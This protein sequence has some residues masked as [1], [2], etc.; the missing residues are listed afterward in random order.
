MKQNCVSKNSEKNAFRL[1]EK[2]YK[3]YRT[4]KKLKESDLSNVIDFDNLELNTSYNKK[5]INKTS[6]NFREKSIYSLEGYDGF[7]FIPN[8][9]SND[10]QIHWYLKAGKEYLLEN[11]S[12][13]TESPQKNGIIKSVSP[14][15]NEGLQ[16]LRW[17]TLGYHF[18]WTERKYCSSKH[19]VFPKELSDFI[20]EI[21]NS[22]GQKIKSECGII[23][24]FH[25][26]SVMCGHVDHSEKDLTKPIISYSLG[27]TA[28]FLLGG[29]SINITPVP[30]FVRSGDIIIMAG[31]T[32]KN[33]HGVPRIL[34][35]TI[36]NY[37]IDAVEK[38]YLPIQLK[39]FLKKIRI[40][41][42]VR[43]YN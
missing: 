14:I 17:V 40:N 23:N 8:A 24:Y 21:S 16:K 39:K 35:N 41:Y 25:E 15:S 38:S 13:L 26:D 30:I 29:N 33:F 43:Q 31:E 37:L 42:N 6:M 27:E 11:P 4:K 19:E 22:I 18:Q 36:P 20:S 34:A 28:I 32:R 9:S 3:T 5:K 7:F 12:N 2:K 1:E 10:E